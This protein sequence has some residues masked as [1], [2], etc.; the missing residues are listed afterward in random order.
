MSFSYGSIVQDALK[1]RWSLDEV[2][3]NV[4][5]LDFSRPFLPESLVHASELDFLDARARLGVN[6]IRANAYLQTFALVERFILPFAVAQAGRSVHGSSE[7]LLALMQFGEEEAKHIVLFEKFAEAFE[8]GFGTR[9]GFVG[10]SNEI[11][12][13]VLAEDPLA[14]ALTVLHIEWMTQDH[15]L[16][17][18]RDDE[19]VD[20]HFKKLL[21]SHWAEEAQHARI[22]T[23]LIAEMVQASTGAGRDRAIRTYLGIWERV[24]SLFAEQ[25]EL[26]LESLARAGIEVGEEHRAA[27]RAGQARSYRETFICAGAR[28][29]RFLEVIDRHFSS[30]R[31]DVE[32]Q[33][34]AWGAVSS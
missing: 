9:C 23:L 12:A 28:H 34:Q 29:E 20:P 27:Y 24:A 8:F 25:V 6:H 16:R 14:V 26:D 5:E 33:A 19:E 31:A 21:R 1:A 18:V 15:Y 7:R 13:S 10:P 32:Q 2:L 30:A 22:D 11:A 3:P 17:S 4:R